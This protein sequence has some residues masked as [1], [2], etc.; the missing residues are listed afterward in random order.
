MAL[1]IQQ[2]TRRLRALSQTAQGKQAEL[3]ALMDETLSSPRVIKA[4]AAEERELNRFAKVAD[5][6]IHAQMRGIRRSALLG[7]SVD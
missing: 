1:A 4:F 2:I 6:A 7:P 5:G 3:N